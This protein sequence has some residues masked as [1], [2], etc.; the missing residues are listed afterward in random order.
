MNQVA[1]VL[2]LW[3]AGVFSAGSALVSGQCSGVWSQVG[4]Q[5]CIRQLSSPLNWSQAVTECQKLDSDL[6]SV[7]SLHMFFSPQTWMQGQVWIMKKN[8][9]DDHETQKC[10]FLNN[11]MIEAGNCGDKHLTICNK[12]IP[13]S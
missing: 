6:P 3:H 8:K 13:A 12:T 10:F 11:G 9:G 4:D 7:N 5:T 2:R 1:T